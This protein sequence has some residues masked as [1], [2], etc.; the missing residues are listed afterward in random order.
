VYSQQRVKT[1]VRE[2]TIAFN[3]LHKKLENELNALL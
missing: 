3:A 2:S 1:I